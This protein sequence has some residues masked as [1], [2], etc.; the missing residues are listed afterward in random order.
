MI[1]YLFSQRETGPEQRST[2]FSGLRMRDGSSREG[3]TQKWA[4]KPS[5]VTGPTMTLRTFPL[6]R[7]GVQGSGLTRSG[8]DC[9]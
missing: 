9:S 5:K 6:H 2:E 1:K 3:G 8:G 7:C 4:A